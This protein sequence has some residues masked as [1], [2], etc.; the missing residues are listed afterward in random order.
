MLV[1][2]RN[3]VITHMQRVITLCVMVVTLSF[4]GCNLYTKGYNQCHIGCNLLVHG[5]NLFSTISSVRRKNGQTW[6]EHRLVRGQQ[7]D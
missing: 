2:L 5:Y 7:M 1:F 3:M 4:H 6:T